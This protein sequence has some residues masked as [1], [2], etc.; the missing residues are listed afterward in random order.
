MHWLQEPTAAY[1]TLIVGPSYIMEGVYPPAFDAAAAQ[2]GSPLK[3]YKLTAGAMSIVEADF[4]LRQLNE[5]AMSRLKLIVW[6]VSFR[7]WDR[8]PTNRFTRRSTYW[9]DWNSLA[10]SARFT[11]W[12]EW[13]TQWGV[14]TLWHRLLHTLAW[15]FKIGAARDLVSR[16]FTPP[17]LQDVRTLEYSEKPSSRRS[18]HDEFGAA[19]TDVNDDWRKG[20]QSIEQCLA[21][22][23]RAERAELVFLNRFAQKMAA[24]N[25][26][27][28]YIVSPTATPWLCR[29]SEAG[30]SQLPLIQYNHP[31]RFPELFRTEDRRN[32]NHLKITG[33]RRFSQTLGEASADLLLASRRV[34][35]R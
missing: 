4:L 26:K 29:L 5:A 16:Q 10:L 32:T 24:R 25:I 12:H 21:S 27:V 7:A 19:L 20:E 9:S 31:L 3:S 11:D 13:N 17:R 28:M 22:L 23:S 30:Q 18:Q 34:V 8:L 15:N 1:D 6:E 33:A 14:L 2:R 35:A